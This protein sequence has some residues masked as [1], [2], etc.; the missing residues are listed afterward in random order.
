M[1]SGRTHVPRLFLNVNRRTKTILT[2]SLNHQLGTSLSSLGPWRPKGLSYQEPPLRSSLHGAPWAS[3]G[4]SAVR[5][6]LKISL[7]LPRCREGQGTYRQWERCCNTGQA[8]RKHRGPAPNSHCKGEEWWGWL[9]VSQKELEVVRIRT[10]KPERFLS[11]QKHHH[12][13]FK[14]AHTV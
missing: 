8:P 13:L 11:C 6:A 3:A 4:T 14:H 9:K 10:R 2:S 1:C 7:C 5:M 12:G